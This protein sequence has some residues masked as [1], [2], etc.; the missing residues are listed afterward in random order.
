MTATTKRLIAAAAI[1][2]LA[3]YAASSV[4]NTWSAASRLQLDHQDL[5]ELRQKLDEI[6]RVADAPRVA[7]LELEEPN[8]IL[9]RINAALKQANL[10]SDL[11]SNQTPNQPQRI[12]QTDF[13]LR[14]VEI[15]LNAATV[16]QIIA[17]CE[18]LRDEA[19]GSLV[20]DLQLFDPRQSG[21]RETWNSQLTLTQIIFSPK[22]DT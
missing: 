3:L 21:S 18:A 8:Q 17:F 11:L 14:R 12:G 22:S 7:A 19:T 6:E 9:D 16:P 4:M 13:K 10:S 2:L 5:R 15:K 20:R 1:V